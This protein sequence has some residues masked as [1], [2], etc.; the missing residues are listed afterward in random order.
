MPASNSFRPH[1]AELLL[2]RPLTQ[3]LKLRL[4]FL[5][6]SRAWCRWTQ[7]QLV[8]FDILKI[9]K[10]C[11]G[12]K[13]SIQPCWPKSDSALPG[14]IWAKSGPKKLQQKAI[15]AHGRAHFSPGNK[16][17]PANWAVLALIGSQIRLK[18]R[19]VLDSTETTLFLGPKQL[20][21]IYRVYQYR[22]MVSR[23]SGQISIFDRVFFVSK[24]PTIRNREAKETCNISRIDYQ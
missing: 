18:N 15:P 23:L 3:E 22:N 21:L 13:V 1:Y 14:A 2:W 6:I 20:F 17:A 4:Q 10:I 19:T 16:S 9:E 24:S 11:F 7:P 5:S 12:P 8:T